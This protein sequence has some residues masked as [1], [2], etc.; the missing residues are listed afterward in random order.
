[1]WVDAFWSVCC[2]LC[3]IFTLGPCV[4][5][6]LAVFLISQGYSGSA[7][8]APWVQ[9]VYPSTY[10][11]S[12]PPT[13]QQIFTEHEDCAK[14]WAHSSGKGRCLETFRLWGLWTSN[15]E[16]AVSRDKH[17][18]RGSE[19]GLWNHIG[20]GTEDGC[21][22]KET[23]L[24]RKICPSWDEKGEWVREELGNAGNNT[25][26]VHFIKTGGRSLCVKTWSKGDTLDLPSLFY[27]FN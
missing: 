20:G 10:S 15:Q 2:W 6:L 24:R 7:F 3:Q 1:M 14:C 8:L 27:F 17:H 12:K 5:S 22:K 9:S 21:L 18:D 23:A 4:Y 11:F 16:M 19:R 26:G 13:T 25:E